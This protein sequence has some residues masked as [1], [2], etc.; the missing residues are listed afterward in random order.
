MTKHII[1]LKTFEF[2][3]IIMCPFD[4]RLMLYLGFVAPITA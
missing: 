2:H 3:S 1:Y 4:F